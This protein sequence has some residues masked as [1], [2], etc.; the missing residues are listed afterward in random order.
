MKESLIIREQAA[1]AAMLTATNMQTTDHSPED[2][3]VLSD[4]EDTPSCKASM[5]IDNTGKTA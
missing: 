4:H 3:L 1:D 5:K 2:G